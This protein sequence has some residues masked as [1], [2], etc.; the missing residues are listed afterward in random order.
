MKKILFLSLIAA[1]SMSIYSA[2]LPANPDISAKIM[3]A[4]HSHFPEVATSSIYQAGDTYIVTFKSAD[5]NS[6]GRIYYDSDG[7]LLQTIRYYDAKE[8]SPFIRA[9]IEATYKDKTILNVTEV[10]NDSEHFYKVILQ[11]A[12]S[13]IVVRVKRNGSMHLEKKYKKAA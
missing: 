9:K 6:S 8:L 1:S 11:D 13:M 2:P 5:N 4:F 7:N 10:E 12:S 3:K